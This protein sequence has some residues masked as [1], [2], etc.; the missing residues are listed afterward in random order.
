[1]TEEAHTAAIA[2]GMHGIAQDF[3]I[4]PTA[5]R[6]KAGASF[7]MHVRHL[8][9]KATDKELPKKLNRW[10]SEFSRDHKRIRGLSRSTSAPKK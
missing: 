5:G 9:T 3:L 10:W 8:V 7:R 1:M 4:Y 2:Q 6:L